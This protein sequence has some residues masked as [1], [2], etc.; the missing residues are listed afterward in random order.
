MAQLV[1]NRVEGLYHTAQQND[2]L[3]VTTT[4]ILLIMLLVVW[5]ILSAVSTS[6][7][8]LFI[9]NNVCIVT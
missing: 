3:H 4:G 7:F 6:L 1:P 9:F 2:E 5:H 8:A